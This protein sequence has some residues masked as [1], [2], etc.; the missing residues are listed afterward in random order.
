TGGI[1]ASLTDKRARRAIRRTVAWSMAIRKSEK[2]PKK[3]D[4]SFAARSQGFATRGRGFSI[5]DIAW[6][7]RFLT[8]IYLAC[9]RRDYY[10]VALLLAFSALR[11]RALHV[12]RFPRSFFQ[13]FVDRSRHSQHSY[14]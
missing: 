5:C 3:K 7:I 10:T 6:P 13:R 4:G 12:Q 14:L 9:A 8:P 2:G 1:S 11:I